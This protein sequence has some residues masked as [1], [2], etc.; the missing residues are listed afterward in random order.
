MNLQN[1]LSF[2]AGVSGKS[3]S[4]LEAPL[5][6][7]L[8]QSG[9]YLKYNITDASLVDILLENLH[10]LLIPT[11][12]VSVTYLLSLPW[13]DASD[14]PVPVKF[15]NYWVSKLSEEDSRKYPK[16]SS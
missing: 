9:A 10:E 4:H 15:G 16:Q 2:C 6:L 11:S 8:K 5:S 7:F 3:P 13:V 14:V 12:D 1:L